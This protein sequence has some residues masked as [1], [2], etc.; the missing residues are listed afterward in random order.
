MTSPRVEPKTRAARRRESAGRNE[1][2]TPRRYELARVD[3]RTELRRM[4][5]PSETTRS[6]RPHDDDR[7]AR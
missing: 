6:G 5:E 1:D 2:A 7:P 3:P 4:T